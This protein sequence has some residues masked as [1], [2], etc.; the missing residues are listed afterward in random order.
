MENL[1][2][3]SKI[4]IGIAGLL[5]LLCTAAIAMATMPS[6]NLEN[7]LPEATQAAWSLKTHRETPPQAS[8]STLEYRGQVDTSKM[9]KIN[10]RETLASTCLKTTPVMSWKETSPC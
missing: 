9:T 7:T 6:W 4:A 1:T 8:T 10:L 3:P 2:R 5:A